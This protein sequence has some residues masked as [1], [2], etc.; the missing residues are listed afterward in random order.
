MTRPTSSIDQSEFS[1]RLETL[2]EDVL[3]RTRENIRGL[4]IIISDHEIEVKKNDRRICPIKC[5][6][7][8]SRLRRR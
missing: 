6:K 7:K 5:S 8:G 2:Q 4:K 1:R 3:E